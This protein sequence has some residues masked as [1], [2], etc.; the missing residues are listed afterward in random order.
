MYELEGSAPKS[1]VLQLGRNQLL[2]FVV[3]G[4][5]QCLLTF[6]LGFGRLMGRHLPDV[7]TSGFGLKV[8]TGRREEGQADI[9]CMHTY[10]LTYDS[11]T[12]FSVSVQTRAP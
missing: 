7:K 1:Q 9:H 8:S 3:I 10:T 4:I 6:I 12:R 11:V 5:H 2:H